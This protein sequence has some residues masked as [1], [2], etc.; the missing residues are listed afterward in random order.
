MQALAV[1][2]G[3]CKPLLT[4]ALWLNRIQCAARIPSGPSQSNISKKSGRFKADRYCKKGYRLNQVNTAIRY[5]LSGVLALSVFS[6]IGC[7]SVNSF[8]SGE[9]AIKEGEMHQKV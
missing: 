8:R 7:D 5:C 2:S 6:L 1:V 3:R 9:Q 4:P